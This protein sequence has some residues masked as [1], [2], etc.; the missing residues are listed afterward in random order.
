MGRG[1]RLPVP[2]NTPSAVDVLMRQCW[3]AAPS[4][5]PEFPYIVDTLSAITASDA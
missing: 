3:H 4:N 5:R 2:A 1:T